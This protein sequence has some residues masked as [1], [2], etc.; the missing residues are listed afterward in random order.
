MSTSEPTIVVDRLT[1]R[2]KGADV[3]AVAGISFSVASGEL[4]ALLGPN[5]AGKTTTISMLTTTLSPT[6]GS[7]RVQRGFRGGI[8]SATS[9]AGSRSP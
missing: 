5:G 1:K 2:Y 4:F 6:S 8:P 3:D 7:A 9:R